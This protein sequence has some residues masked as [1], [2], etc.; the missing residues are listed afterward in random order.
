MVGL[1]ARG[2]ST[3]ANRIKETLIRDDIQTEIFN[4]GDLRRQLSKEDTSYAGFYSQ[5]NKE[6]AA[7]REKI[8]FINIHKAI[9]FL[10]NKDGD[11][12]ILDA[13]NISRRRRTLIREKL[14]D[15]PILFIEC[16]NP[17]Q[18]ILEASIARKAK[19]PE[20]SHL[21][22][23]EALA[24]FKERI[25]YY[26]SIRSPLTDE[27]NFIKLD[28]LNNRILESE[29]TDTVP[30]IDRLR[31]LLLT[32]LVRNL[33]L[34]R[35][36]ETY[37]NLQS[38][39]GGDSSLTP[40]GIEQAETLAQT[41]KKTP[42]PYI[43]TSKKKRT[44]E[45]ANPICEQQEKKCTIIPLEEF[46]EIYSG[47]CESMSYAEIKTFMPEVDKE[48]SKDKYNY[49]YPEGEGYVTMEDRINKGIKKALFLSGNAKHIMIV[50]HRAVN[51][52][53]LA[54]FL[55]RRKEDVPYIFIPQD[56]YFHIIC[57]QEK[58]LF[59]LKP[60]TNSNTQN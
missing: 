27:R 26:E 32:D 31:D 24:S 20:F 2:K 15:H 9:T 35:H 12:A 54:H 58:K 7:L 4:N 34:V 47:I 23:D 45:T 6:A 48:R 59:E 52:M 33:Y 22:F 50:G 14:L 51:R 60:L 21:T 3:I 1:P 53:I 41:F 19:L 56:K 10:N 25:A 30:Y 44:L 11:V 43:F 28:T 16:E 36:G 18:E 5:E 46:N 13:T 42:L 49:V 37:Y 38:M 55:F 57:T 8:A 17:D 39:I 29:F 40:K